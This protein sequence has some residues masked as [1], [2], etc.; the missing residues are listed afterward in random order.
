MTTIPSSRVLRDNGEIL[1]GPAAF[2]VLRGVGRKDGMLVPATWTPAYVGSRLVGA[3]HALDRL[4]AVRGPRSLHAG[5]TPRDYL[6]A[7]EDGVGLPPPKTT[8]PRTQNTSDQHAAMEQALVWPSSYC[9][10]AQARVVNQWA[11]WTSTHMSVKRN[12]RACG[13]DL[14][15]FKDCRDLGLQQIASGLARDRVPVS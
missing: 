5:G 11:W 9:G 6:H 4:P 15:S 14:S 3:F 10:D 12:A 7:F 8:V 1:E 13:W 2:Q